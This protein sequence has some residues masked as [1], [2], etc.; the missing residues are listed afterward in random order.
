MI[1]LDENIHDQRIQSGIVEWY[2]GPVV[3]I[4]TLRPN[5]VIKDDAIPTLLRQA[6]QPTFLTIN[7]QDFWKR[8]EPHRRFAIVNME[9]TPAQIYEIPNLLQRLFRLDEFKTK[10]ARMGKIIRLNHKRVEYYETRQQTRRI[11][12]PD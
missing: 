6:S 5:S 10:S 1:I 11:R 4:R 8:I 2:P 7:A 3:S 12:L 9:L